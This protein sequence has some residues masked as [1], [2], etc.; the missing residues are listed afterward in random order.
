MAT[1]R[2]PRASTFDRLDRAEDLL[3]EMGPR[4]HPVPPPLLDDAFAGRVRER[5]EAGDP[6]KPLLAELQAVGQSM[7]FGSQGVRNLSAD[8]AR[9]LAE[10]RRLLGPHPAVQEPGRG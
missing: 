7:S 9:I 3:N 4:S 10:A 8:A 6:R 5:M 2:R 1:R